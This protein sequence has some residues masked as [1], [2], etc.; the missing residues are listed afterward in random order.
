MSGW[1]SSWPDN[2]HRRPHHGSP[3]VERSAVAHDKR[4][5]TRKRRFSIIRGGL[6]GF[7][8][9]YGRF[10]RLLACFV[11]WLI[12]II[13]TT[14]PRLCRHSVLSSSPLCRCRFV[15]SASIIIINH[16]ASTRPIRIDS[17]LAFSQRSLY[18]LDN[19][20]GCGG[21][22]Q[23]PSSRVL[24]YVRACLGGWG[25]DSAVLLFACFATDGKG[26]G[27]VVCLWFL[28]AFC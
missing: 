4:Q 19:W 13:I 20:G 9:F 23:L 26:G 10:A 15:F 7:N 6:G 22:F 2:D 24:V 21:L 28:S 18:W 3:G 25:K 12:I 27:R 14:T 5:R 1:T 17:I 11:H 8:Y 16:P